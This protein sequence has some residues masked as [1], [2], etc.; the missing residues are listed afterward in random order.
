M[1]PGWEERLIGAVAGHM[2]TPFA[3]GIS[4]CFRMMMDSV[5]AVTG[6][7]PYR[8]ERGRY[9]S[10]RGAA[11]RIRR[12]GFDDLEAMIADRFPR[13]PMALAQR[14]DLAIIAGDE[15]AGGVVIGAEIAAKSRQG[16]IRIPLDPGY[17][18]FSVR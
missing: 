12:N 17:S 5:E 10:E 2:A 6:E 1:Q 15:V 9:S 16:V 4:D 14:G 3:W 11:L 8:G 7:D 18:Y 13:V